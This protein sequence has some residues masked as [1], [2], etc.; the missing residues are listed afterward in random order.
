MECS[1]LSVPV[2]R[3]TT[4]LLGLVALAIEPT[5][6]SADVPNNPARR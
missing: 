6:S 4:E 1:K 2:I 3:F 5:P